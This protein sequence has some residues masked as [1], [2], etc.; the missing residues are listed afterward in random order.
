MLKWLWSQIYFTY[1]KYTVWNTRFQSL[2]C[3]GLKLTILQAFKVV[4]FCPQKINGI[5]IARPK[6]HVTRAADVILVPKDEFS[7]AESKAGKRQRGRY[8]VAGAPSQQSCQNRSFTPGIRMYKF[9]KDPVVRGKW[10]QFVRRHRHDFKD[11]TS[12]YTSLCS[13][14]FEESCY[15]KNLAVLSSME[16]QGLKMNWCLKRDAVPTRDTIVPPAPEE[17]SDR[18]KRQVSF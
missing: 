15:E 3:L 6:Y 9:P 10:V 1:L 4:L 17:L 13:A 11:P 2:R 14:H 18:R 5:R 7:M 12:A 8:C 16:A